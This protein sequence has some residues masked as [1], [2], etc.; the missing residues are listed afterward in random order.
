MG[1]MSFADA[2]RNHAGAW[3]VAGWVALATLLLPSRIA[4]AGDIESAKKHL[5]EAKDALK[6]Q[7]WSTLEEELK[8]TGDFLDGVPDAERAPVMKELTALKK[9]AE[10]KIAAVKSQKIVERITRDIDS[11]A[12]QA[13]RTP[14]GAMQALKDVNEKLASEDARKYVDPATLKKLQSRA[15]GLQQMAVKGVKKRVTE[16][17]KPLVDELDQQVA[18]NPFKD[19]QSNETS[20]ISQSLSA[21]IS[22]IRGIYDAL[23]KDDPDVKAM[24]AKLDGIARKIDA[25]GADSDKAGVV[26]RIADYWKN[27]KNYFEGW[28]AETAGPNWERYT[29]EGSQG[30]SDLLMPKTVEAINR[31]KY[32]FDSEEVKKAQSTYPD[33]PK[34]KAIVAEAQKTLDTA[35]GKM[36]D[37]FNKLLEEAE[38]LPTPRKNDL[39]F[40][41]PGYMTDNAKRWFAGTKFEAPNIERATKLKEKWEGATAANEK[42]RE[43]AFKDLVKQSDAAWPGIRSGIQAE[44]GFNPAEADKWKGKTIELKGV[45]NRAGWDYSGYDFAMAINGIPVAGNYAPN[46]NEAFKAV[47]EKTSSGPDDHTD[48]DVIAVVEGPGKIGERTSADV[49]DGS[50]TIGKIEGKRSVDCVVLKIVGLHAGPI[51]I[52]PGMSGVAAVGGTA[53]AASASMVGDGGGSGAIGW[54]WRIV[55][56][57]VLL[58]GAALAFLKARPN[59]IPA[60]AVTPA[61]EGAAGTATATASVV[62]IS[63]VAGLM[64]GDTP[65]I[66]GLTLIA[67]GVLTLLFGLIIRDLL[68]AL[69][70]IAAGAYIGAEFLRGKGILKGGMYDQIRGL[71]VPIAGAAAAIAVLHLFLGGH[72]LF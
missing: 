10:P 11:A 16:N 52:G 22:R 7:N 59:A 30:M 25:Y 24:N 2:V 49:R 43:D 31:T 14:D 58:A 70:F 21:E 13:N 64:S 53:S 54:M 42:A 20:S 61:A 1:H 38:K 48:W 28:E 65:G 6:S 17:A 19:K 40:N 62:P 27:T 66:L 5:E 50:T 36:N 69:A 3:I 63:P 9:E 60:A 26:A 57:L 71:G 67:F 44:S 29:K 32:W 41:K 35:L 18:D 4:L 68:P 33:E 56:C 39:S 12:D 37:N 55:S 51:A 72:W 46:V 34:L 23:P 47:F 45:R 8:S 15:D